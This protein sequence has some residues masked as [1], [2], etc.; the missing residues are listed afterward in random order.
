MTI[1][2]RLDEVFSRARTE[3]RRVLIPYLTG[4]FPTPQ[5]FVDVAVSVLQAGADILEIGIPFSDPLL[6][7]TAIQRSQQI[8]LEAGTTPRDCVAFAGEISRRVDKP[9]V[10]MG[11]YNPILAYGLDRFCNDAASSGA[12]GV[13]VPDLPLEESAELR[14]AT[15]AHGMHVI[16]MVAP[17]STPQ[18]MQRVCA[19][20]S[21]FI[22]CVSVAGVTGQRSTVSDAARPLVDRVRGCSG[23]PV[24]VGFGIAGPDQAR[25]VGRFADGVIVGAALIT[26]VAESSPGTEARA[27]GAFVASL[28]E[29]LSAA[30]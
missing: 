15:A 18:R 11:A 4:G 13:I 7:G 1:R 5:S 24:A 26:V 8:A 28:A 3:D 27:A 29:A 20:A 19:R 14:D 10:F 12:A 9:L 23:V 22:Y 30:A 25:Q 6:D 2:N 17:T 16:Q 21:G